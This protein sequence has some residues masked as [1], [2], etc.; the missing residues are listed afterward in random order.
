MSHSTVVPAQ[1]NA[2]R[3]GNARISGTTLR[4]KRW[5]HG[6]LMPKT[7]AITVANLLRELGQRTALRGGNPYR[8]KAYLRAADNLAALGIPLERAVRTNQL[9]HIFG[10]AVEIF[11]G[12]STWTG[13]GTDARLN[14]AAS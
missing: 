10:V 2:L 8:A 11:R 4:S 1:P 13:A 14:S 5:G 3:M 7:D 9:V 6:S 12:G